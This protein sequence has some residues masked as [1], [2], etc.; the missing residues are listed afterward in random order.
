[1]T[2][3]LPVIITYQDQ[4][5]TINNEPAYKWNLKKADWENFTS[6]VEANLP[7]YY[8]KKNVNKVEKALRKSI[9]EQIHQE[10]EGDTEHQVV[11]NSGSK[12]CRQEKERT[13]QVVRRE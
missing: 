13:E 9:G 7:Q 6:M 10:K 1:M 11:S 12:G 8:S 2:D 5:S 4:F 3:H